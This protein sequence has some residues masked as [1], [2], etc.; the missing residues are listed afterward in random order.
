MAWSQTDIDTLRAAIARGSRRA[1][2]ANQK[3]EYRSIEEML[4]ALAAIRR[5]V[6][7]QNGPDAPGPRHRV[8]AFGDSNWR[9]TTVLR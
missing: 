2:F 7:A 8:A 9:H 1:R 6:S 4:S 5:A 3:E